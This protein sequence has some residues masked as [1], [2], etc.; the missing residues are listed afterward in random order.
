MK[1]KQPI[2]KY[3][4]EKYSILDEWNFNNGRRMLKLKDVLT[5]NIVNAY[6]DKVLFIN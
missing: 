5:G 6:K 2:V 1:T 4:L 3:N